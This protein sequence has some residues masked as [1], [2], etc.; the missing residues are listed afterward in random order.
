M[1]DTKQDLVWQYRYFKCLKKKKKFFFTELPLHRRI[2][3]MFFLVCVC[4]KQKRQVSLCCFWVWQI[5]SRGHKC[6]HENVAY[7][8]NLI[9]RKTQTEWNKKIKNLNFKTTKT[10]PPLNQQCTEKDW[11]HC[12]NTYGGNWFCKHDIC[13]WFLT[14]YM[15]GKKVFPPIYTFSS[16][17]IVHSKSKIMPERPTVGKH[18]KAD[19][20]PHTANAASTPVRHSQESR[21]P[22]MATLISFLL[23]IL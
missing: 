22:F 2:L 12:P 11:L 23:V 17:N 3:T 8:G 18:A 13:P 21:R 9:T 7:V 4:P 14:I 10:T 6:C 19:P 1:L 16:E 15:R 20:P 5:L